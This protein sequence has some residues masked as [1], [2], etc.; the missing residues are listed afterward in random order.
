[1]IN[2]ILSRKRLTLFFLFFGAYCSILAGI[3]YDEFFHIE[4]GQ[5]RLRYLF[6]LGFYD[7]NSILHLKYYPGL[8]DTI[9]S[10]IISAFP[11]TYMN[12]FY[13]LI[14][15][16]VGVSGLFGL[17]KFVKIIFNKKI[18]DIFFLLCAFAPLYFGHLGINPKD[19]IIA[20]SNFWIMYYIIKYSI[21]NSNNE[22]SLIAT[23]IGMLIGFGAGVRIMFLGTLIPIIIF[24]LLEIFFFRKITYKF[25]I[26][27]FFTHFIKIISISYLLVILCWPDVHSNIIYKPFSL[28]FESLKDLSQGVQVSYFAGNFY[29]TNDTPWFYIIK[30]FF[31]KIPVF[32]LFLFLL[33]FI[34]FTPM[35]IYYSKRIKHYSY[36]FFICL[37]LLF[38][39]ILIAIILKLKIHDGLRYFI[40]LIPIFNIIPSIFLIYLIENKKKLIN[41]VVL[42]FLSPLILYFAISF[43]LITPYQ[44]S[45]LNLF[46]KYMMNPNSFENDYWGISIKKLAKDFVNT[47]K[48]KYNTKIASCGLN[49]DVLEYYLNKYGVKNYIKSDMNEDFD[50]AVLINRAISSYDNNGIKNQTCFQKF[51]DKQD[52]YIL[53]KNSIV[54]SKIIKY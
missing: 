7:Y 18:S 13:H 52:L 14:N 3:S 30:N 41:K 23:K 42:F 49:D 24:F 28:F 31:F 1:M 6:S 8:Y 19:T 21:K 45:Y 17:K 53:S 40:Y 20:S 25:N 10:L 11:K 33:S 32:Y 4:N 29:E 12:E 50:Y 37:F 9:S 48:I 46:N 44:Y 22:K 27:N 43:I 39:P 16:L 2:K 51:Y 36:F 15:F 35:K 38:F 34:F 54:L 26:N 5:K 47:K